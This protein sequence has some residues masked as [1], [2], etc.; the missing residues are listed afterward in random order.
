VVPDKTIS[1]NHMITQNTI[2]YTT[3]RVVF[4]IEDEMRDTMSKLLE[5]I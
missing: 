3:F 5:I 2:Y 1:N 4:D